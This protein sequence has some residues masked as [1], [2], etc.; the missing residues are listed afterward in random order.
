M[1]ALRRAGV[2]AAWLAVFGMSG[3]ALAAPDRLH[4]EIDSRSTFALQ[5]VLNPLVRKSADL[6]RLDPALRIDNVTIHFRRSPQQQADLEALLSEQQTP[7]SPAW[8]QWLTPQQFGERFG[9]GSGDLQR[10]KRWLERKGLRVTDLSAARNQLTISG[11]VGGIEEAFGV[12]LHRYRYDGEMHFASAGEPRLP[13]ALKGMML[14]LQHLDDFRLKPM[15]V[16]QRPAP[17]DG[18]TPQFNSGGDHQLV[19]DDLATIYDIKPLYQQSIDGTGISIA[20]VGRAV[21][22]MTDIETFREDAKLPAND[23]NVI[24]VPGTEGSTSGT[25]DPND[26]LE[27]DLDLEWAGAIAYGAT[28]NFVTT[29]AADGFD[30]TDSLTYAIQSDL[31]P[32]IS[33]SY[34]LCEPQIPA[35]ELATF[36]S[37]GQQANA[38]GQ[39]IIVSAGDSGAAG[40]DLQDR[41]DT[42]KATQG[43]AVL[44]P[45]DLAEVTAVGG[46]EFSGD[47][48]SPTKYWSAFNGSNG[49]SAKTYIPETAWNDSGSNGLAASGG[50]V[51]TLVAKPDWQGGTGVPDDGQRDVPDIALTASWVHDPYLICAGSGGSSG[52]TG[53]CAGSGFAS[54]TP[55]SI[56]GTSASA[57][58]FAGMLALLEQSVGSTGAGNVNLLLYTLAATSSTYA[59]VFHDITTGSNAVPCVSGSTDCP[60]GTTSFGYDAGTGYDLATGLGSIDVNEMAKAFV[61]TQLIP[62][63]ST[64]VINPNRVQAGDWVTLTASITPDTQAA[65]AV[66]GTV[67]F[68]LDGTNIGDPVTVVNKQATLK[69]TIQNTGIHTI[70]ATYSGGSTYAL[71]HASGTVSVLALPPAQDSKDGGGGAVPPLMIGLLAGLAG[72][73]RRR[74][75]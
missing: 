60:A 16:K 13:A 49:G 50:G 27:S 17:A 55:L 72:W 67:Q 44:F 32:I 12:E 8:H 51:S 73:R 26:V 35:D 29:N 11:S 41:P 3:A 28:I 68:A 46:T 5:G 20:V 36:Q 45:A 38:Q 56:G 43:I 58:V 23:P 10:V 65:D 66:L 53:T 59:N 21:V 48:D 64:V 71:S 57:P 24:S 62:T 2:C 74:R 47:V 75:A 7:G 25:S 42:P 40:C 39:T 52:S 14:S 6:G 1:K 63:R 4:S 34:G 30:V 61:G 18:V 37:L 31:A 22:D 15:G 70:S 9:V 54:D 69:I 19:P 33:M